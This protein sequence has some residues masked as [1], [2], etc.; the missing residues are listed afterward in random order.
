MNAKAEKMRC[1]I[2]AGDLAAVRHRIEKGY[3]IN[4]K[5]IRKETESGGRTYCFYNTPMEFALY[6]KQ[7][8]IVKLFIESGADMPSDNSPLFRAIRH[9]RP[10]LFAFMVEHGA[11]LGKN[12]R[13]VVQ[14]LANLA[15]CWDSAYI[16][17][18][19]ALKMPVRKYGAD[20][21]FCAAKEN[22]PGMAEY[23]LSLGVDINARNKYFHNTPVLCAAENNCFEM[24]RFFTE[25]GADLSLAN[26]YGERPYTAARKNRNAEMVDYIRKREPE[27]LHSEAAQADKF[28][29]YHVPKAME[30]YLKTGNLR[31]VFP[32]ESHL[33]WIQLY[34]YM[35]VVE[36]TYGDKKVL[37]L[38]EDSDDGDIVLVWDPGSQ[39]VCYVDTERETLR[40]AG[41][42]EEFIS[43]PDQRLE[44]VIEWANPL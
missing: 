7:Y 44:D 42:W 14:L 8:D 31:L 43:A 35:D 39:K 17:W 19:A 10:D 22:C 33:S 11:V 34:S 40:R 6:Q 26:R 30:D 36:M 23:L 21:L 24:V 28:A 12:K 5:N 13:A 27:E 38:V 1:A 18:I 9:H 16:P 41:T 29:A 20:G 37:S 2:I 25:H 3:P 4:E 15:P 32:E